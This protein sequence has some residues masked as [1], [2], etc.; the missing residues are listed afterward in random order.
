MDVRSLPRPLAS[1]IDHTLL[2]PDAREAEVRRLL[3]EAAAAGFAAAMV[4]PCWVGL[5]ARELAGS[6]VAPATVIA[7]PLGYA[8]PAAR[9]DE[10]RHAVDDG[11]RELDTVINLSRLKSG[12]D[13]AVAD[14]LGAWVAALRGLDPDLVLKVIVET[15]LLDDGEKARA[16]RLVAAAGADYVK[17]STGFGPGGATVDDV[18]RLAA[19]VAGTGLRVKAS[20]GIRDLPGALALIAAGADRLGTSAGTALLAAARRESGGRRATG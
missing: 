14:D 2:K 15:A 4:P 17:T 9:R 10:S 5:A 11:A 19:A 20:G 3:A 18:R 16:A 6:G 13:A 8:S 12:E 7:F 1:Y